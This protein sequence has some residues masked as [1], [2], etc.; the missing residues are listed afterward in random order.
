MG[1][2]PVILI[3]RYF[4]TITPGSVFSYNEWSWDTTQGFKRS[5]LTTA[6]SEAMIVAFPINGYNFASRAQIPF[7]TPSTTTIATS[8]V[9]AHTRTAIPTSV[10]QT[11]SSSSANHFSTGFPPG[12][13]PFK[14]AT[15]PNSSRLSTAAAIGIGSGSVIALIRLVAFVAFSFL[16]RKK[17]RARELRRRQMTSEK[18]SLGNPDHGEKCLTIN[19][20]NVLLER[21]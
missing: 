20:N 3:N 10:N 4:S 11:S 17:R 9:A 21:P 12:V 14:L 1:S 13:N 8:T 2:E 16:T 18:E 19:N 15:A 7:T 6:G 5:V